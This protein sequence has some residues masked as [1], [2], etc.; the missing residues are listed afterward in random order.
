MA[1][2]IITPDDKFNGNGATTVF[3][4]TFR[5]FATTDIEVYLIDSS[6][7]ATLQTAGVDYTITLDSDGEGGAVTMTTAPASGAKLLVIRAMTQDQPTDFQVE[8]SFPEGDIE[9]GYDR[10]L[11]LVQQLQEQ[12]DRAIKFTLGTNEANQVMPE[13]VGDKFMQWKTDATALKLVGASDI[14]S[15]ALASGELW[16]SST[17]VTIANGQSAA[18]NITGMITGTAKFELFLYGVHRHSTTDE[19]LI[20]GFIFVGNDKNSAEQI[21]KST[22]FPIVGSAHGLTFSLSGTQFQYISDTIGGSTY[23]GN[24]W[25]KK[26]ILG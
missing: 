3:T 24:I 16:S 6:L 22:T 12:I 19:R 17:Q 25:F 26:V 18:T 15:E 8:A 5:A 11:M 23:V 10:N 1:V 14:L 7:V 21:N 4:Y 20:V 9:N 2:S 13:P